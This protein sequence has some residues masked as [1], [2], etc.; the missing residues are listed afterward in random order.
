MHAIDFSHKNTPNES[1]WEKKFDEKFLPEMT[2]WWFF[3]TPCIQF[4][5]KNFFIHNRIVKFRLIKICVITHLFELNL[6]ELASTKMC[7]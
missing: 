5:A 3:G 7:H 2:N 4:L 6:M 1:F